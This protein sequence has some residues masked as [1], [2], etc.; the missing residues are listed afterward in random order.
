MKRFILLLQTAVI[1][2][3]FM[4]GCS[5][6]SLGDSIDD[7]NN[8]NNSSSS[9]DTGSSSG[10]TSGATTSLDFTI[11]MDSSD[12][13]DYSSI[14]ETVPTNSSDTNYDDFVEN[15]TFGSTVTIAYS[16][17]TAT[18]TNNVSGVTITTSGANVTVT[19]TATGV[20]YILS[21][22]TS[23]GSFKMASS[24]KK[25]EVTLNGVA[26]TNPTGAAINLQSGK[27]AF[28]VSA[29]GTTNTLT[30]G[31]SYTEVTNEDMKGCF[32][33]EGQAIFSGTGTLT[34]KGN[35]KHAIC[36]DDYIRLRSGSNITISGAAKDGIHTNDGLIIGGGT[37]NIT[38]TGDGIEVDEGPIT[39]TNGLITINSA[40]DAIKT[41]YD[42]T[43]TTITPYIYLEGGLLK[44]TTTGE[45]AHGVKAASNIVLSGGIVQ[46]TVS[47]KGSK[48]MSSDGT[49]TISGGKI[50]AITS[51]DALY[52]D[53]D[54]T[55][56]AGLKSNGAI[57]I[58]G[59]TIQCKSSG[60]GGKGISGDATCNITGGTIKIITT[61]LKY[62]Y[63]S[64]LDTS[65]KGIKVDGNL[66]IGGGAVMVRTEGGG[67][68]GGSEGIESKG[69]LTISGGETAVSAPDD[70]INAAKSIVISGGK[71]YAYSS[72][73]D[74]IDSN[75]SMSVS[76]GVTIASGT[77]QP[78]EGFD[79]D[80]NT[81]QI[82]GGILIGTGGAS[83]TMGGSQYSVA[84]GGSGSSGQ[85]ITIKASDGTIL[86]SYKLPRAYN[87]MVL[88]F[89]SP[90][91]KS[92]TK[93]TIYAGGTISGGSE[94]YGYYTGQTFSGGTSLSTFTP[95]AV[96]TTVGNVSSQGGGGQGGQGG[97]PGR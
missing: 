79:C 22:S 88:T 17:S 78:E 93:Y 68:D 48:G 85:F 61:G 35:C 73:N 11:G 30:D 23:N 39:I 56:A 84:Y 57:T 29:E 34:V 66:T 62:S 55:G 25:Y 44:L 40:G 70:A 43:D 31:T 41:S 13:T 6:G 20:N 19:S 46:A 96:Y 75:G 47:G 92:G 76:G 54:L 65:A 16:G 49:M 86:M 59:G 14:A 64:S 36:S 4:S 15:S 69:I 21:G 33:T 24:S 91:M 27:R 28:I 32:F 81:L 63:S 72:G 67:S 94:F 52:E 87:S 82:T 38:A 89:S 1:G 71:T 90:S 45:T 5:S 51:G 9:T 42:G 10:S 7:I 53:N 12:D 83:S 58:S 37:L 95:S 18:V 2:L 3:L 8:N 50:T 60:K 26:I 97:G 74:G 77:T 80:N